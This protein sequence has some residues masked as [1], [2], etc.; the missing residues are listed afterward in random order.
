[1]K[2]QRA[3]GI[4]ECEFQTFK[5][6]FERNVINSDH[7]FVLGLQKA[8]KSSQNKRMLPKLI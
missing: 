6:G 2:L 5:Q 1:M 3:T 7:F 8:A 4:I